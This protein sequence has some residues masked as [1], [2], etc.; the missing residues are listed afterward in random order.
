MRAQLLVVEAES[1]RIYSGSTAV[2]NFEIGSN[3]PDLAYIATFIGEGAPRF[4]LPLDQQ[5]RNQNFAQLLLIY[6]A[7]INELADRP[8]WYHLLTRT[9]LKIP[10]CCRSAINEE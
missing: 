10:D 3:N 8:E 5:L 7:R 1:F 9:Y 2:G 6:L 4:Y